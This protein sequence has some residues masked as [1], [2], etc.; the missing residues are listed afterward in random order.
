MPLKEL[1][2]LLSAGTI[3][4]RTPVSTKEAPNWMPL[5]AVESIRDQVLAALKAR[6]GTTQP[7]AIQ[8]TAP[9]QA[10]APPAQPAPAKP[11]PVVVP[12]TKPKNVAKASPPVESARPASLGRRL[13]A[14][15]LDGVIVGGTLF[16]LGVG[17][18]SWIG[19]SGEGGIRGPALA[20][21][22]AFALLAMWLYSSWME[23]SREQGTAGKIVLDLKV[24]DVAGARLSFAR[25]SIR[26]LAKLVSALTLGA[27]LLTVL[28][29]GRRQAL[30]DL[31]ARS[32]VVRG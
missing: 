2:R 32:V 28:F 1:L 24:S 8:P 10:P 31:I 18:Q 15:I 6:T 7:V 17:F 23:S 26:F 4:L 12:I 9:A 5:S 29:T 22:V 14:D 13:A 19:F 16:V 27:G 30:H 25:A 11:A 20:A 3:G 21:A